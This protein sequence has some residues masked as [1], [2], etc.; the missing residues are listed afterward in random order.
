MGRSP[1]MQVFDP[2]KLPFQ[3][4]SSPI[5]QFEIK[6]HFFWSLCSFTNGHCLF[7]K[8][9]CADT[10]LNDQSRAAEWRAGVLLPFPA[11]AWPVPAE[12]KPLNS[13]CFQ[14][15]NQIHQE[16]RPLS[17]STR[18]EAQVLHWFVGWICVN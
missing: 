1:V 14:A 5:E 3:P 15:H 17:A 6:C 11:H 10:Q 8:C 12:G 18:W 9:H 16:K 2:N 7:D 4:H 13:Q